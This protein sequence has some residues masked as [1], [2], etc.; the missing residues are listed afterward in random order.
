MKVREDQSCK[1]FSPFNKKIPGFLDEIRGLLS[2]LNHI[3]LSLTC[4]RFFRDLTDK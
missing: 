4:G 2:A 1:K 3:L